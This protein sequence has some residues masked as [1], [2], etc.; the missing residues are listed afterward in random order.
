MTITTF[1]HLSGASNCD[2]TCFSSNARRFYHW[3]TMN[4]LLVRWSIVLA[5]SVLLNASTAHAQARWLTQ[6]TKS[7]TNG[8]TLP[9]VLEE[10]SAAHGFKIEYANDKIK[11]Q[12]ESDVVGIEIVANLEGVPLETTLNLLCS[13]ASGTTAWPWKADKATLQMQDPN[14]MILVTHSIRGFGQLISDPDELK[15]AIMYSVDADWADFEEQPDKA[16]LM[17]TISDISAASIMVRQVYRGQ[18]EVAELLQ[19]LQAAA[20]GKSAHAS[21]AADKKTDRILDKAVSLSAGDITLEEL[22][23]QAFTANKIPWIAMTEELES[24]KVSLTDIVTLDGKKQPLRD[25]VAGTLEP[26][27]LGIM[28][29]DGIVEISSME[30][31][32]YRDHRRIYNVQKLLNQATTAE[33]AVKIESLEG[34]TIDLAVPLGPFVIVDADSDSHK[35]ISAA[36]GVK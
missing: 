19:E 5:V 33:I 26:H 17:G 35:K 4:S 11:N 30:V 13:R 20:S 14:E 9:D 34:T 2:T 15:D 8:K 36:L 21:S 12:L 18:Q 31:I 23:A 10:L 24:Q 27:K 1:C 3:F 29:K 22:F 25:T 16:A 6:K 7:F 32:D 28:V